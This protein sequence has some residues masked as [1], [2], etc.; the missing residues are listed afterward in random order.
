MKRVFF[1]LFSFFSLSALSLPRP[2]ENFEPGQFL[3]GG[4]Y[5][6]NDGTS[7]K[8]HSYMNIG[9][10]YIHMD[11]VF[12]DYTMSYLFGYNMD[13]YGFFNIQ[14]TR[15]QA[16][17]DDMTYDGIG[18]CIDDYCHYHVEFPL[19]FVEETVNFE[20]NKI[21]TVGSVHLKYVE[22]E[23]TIWKENLLRMIRRDA[24]NS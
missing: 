16:G 17:A 6:K 11:H 24:A 3:G 15:T 8:F 23:V 9:S 12:G 22:E 10:D 4:D 21:T 18:Y 13:Q 5:Q 7:G 14:M 20:A 1:L 19:G 2:L